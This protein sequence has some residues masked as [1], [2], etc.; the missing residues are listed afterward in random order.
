MEYPCDGRDCYDRCN[1]H[2]TCFSCPLYKQK[3]EIVEWRNDYGLDQ[4]EGQNA[5][6]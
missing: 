3:M 1:W 5:G 4:R 6:G 2:V